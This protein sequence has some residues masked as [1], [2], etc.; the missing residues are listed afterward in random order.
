MPKKDP[1]SPDFEGKRNPNCQHFVITFQQV[2][3]NI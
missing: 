1:I 3:K 2:A